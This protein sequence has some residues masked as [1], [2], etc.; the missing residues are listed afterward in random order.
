M[1]AVIIYDDFGCA[2][3][4]K[5]ML[6]R[7]AHRADAALLWTVKP[8]RLDMLMPSLKAD[9]AL[10]D[11]TNAHLIVLVLRHPLSFPAWV[12]DWLDLWAKRREVL[13]AALAVWDDGN[14]DTLSASA[15]PELSRLARRHGLTFLFRDAAPDEDESATS[16][17]S[18]HEHEVFATRR[19][20]HPGARAA[21]PIL[22]GAMNE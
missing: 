17:A 12:S 3:K 16:A 7:A 11:A 18:P 5:V 1:N 22:G 8:W 2:A 20:C 21:S 14:G 19:C 10:T 13:D 4:A 9:A 6:E 15:A